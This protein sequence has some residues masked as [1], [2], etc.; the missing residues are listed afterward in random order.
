M[1]IWRPRRKVLA[2]SFNLHN[3]KGFVKIFSK[4][5]I[6]LVDKLNSVAG[7][8]PV[9]MWK[10]FETY[11]MDALCGM[12]KCQT[13]LLMIDYFTLIE[14]LVQLDIGNCVNPIPSY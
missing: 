1:S 3:L 4:Q 11:S 12:W 10:Y 6:I 9:P 7:K 5:S 8:D 14:E 13:Y 2:P